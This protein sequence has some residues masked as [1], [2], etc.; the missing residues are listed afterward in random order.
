MPSETDALFKYYSNKS[1]Y[2]TIRQGETIFMT[3]AKSVHFNDYHIHWRLHFFWTLA[4][5]CF[6]F[7][8]L[9][10]LVPLPGYEVLPAFRTYPA[11]FLDTIF[12]T[13]ACALATRSIVI[14][15][16]KS[17]RDG[18]H[19]DSIVA[20]GST[21]GFAAM[22]SCI[23]HRSG[24]RYFLIAILVTACTLL[25]NALEGELQSTVRI[26]YRIGGVTSLNTAECQHVSS[27]DYMLASSAYASGLITNTISDATS[28]LNT[29]NASQPMKSFTISIIK[30]SL[31]PIQNITFLPPQSNTNILRRHY[32]RPKKTTT[33]SAVQEQQTESI[34]GLYTALIT[35]S[36]TS[37]P[38]S[39][40]PV[41]NNI[42]TNNI[43]ANTN[44][45]NMN[46]DIDAS[47][48]S[49]TTA[50]TF[51]N[52]ITA[53]TTTNPIAASTTTN[54]IAASTNAANRITATAN[55][56]NL[57][58]P[59]SATGGFNQ[60]SPLAIIRNNNNNRTAL[61]YEMGQVYGASEIPMKLNIFRYTT[62]DN[63]EAVIMYSS[64]TN[65]Y[66][67]G[68]Y[69][70]VISINHTCQSRG[71]NVIC[72]E[73]IS[74]TADKKIVADALVA[75]VRSGDGLYG[76]NSGTG[77]TMDI[78]NGINSTGKNSK[79]V[80][81]LFANPLCNNPDLIPSE[82][83]ILIPYSAARL[84]NLAIIW[85]ILFI[86]LWIIGVYLIGYTEHTWT[87]LASTGNML[88][89]IIS[90]SPNMFES[91]ELGASTIQQEM[92][93]DP[94]TGQMT[95]ERVYRHGYSITTAVVG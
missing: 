91:N 8:K 7:A 5:V 50:S 14:G 90:K 40:I 44:D 95:L 63:Q 68:V 9:W 43:E 88:P 80:D 59:S 69:V 37:S 26:Y 15:L 39:T 55:M 23:R 27:K 87:Q 51:G 47:I 19:P 57:F 21:G 71:D 79:L 84:S 42:D 6:I 74:Y 28:L 24:V 18:I 2:R 38:S 35:L 48:S 83:N 70:N 49:S 31:A 61:P 93:L 75:A 73:G 58:I 54:T 17:F 94:E 85:L 52:T 22:W 34:S 56:Q 92:F 64:Q 20:F 25:G 82:G 30:T 29:L 81:S 67:A 78:V 77:L 16:L 12:L 4:V 76:T 72:D 89:Q 65:E 10:W 62:P 41:F 66:N 45:K 33:E 32:P 13:F 46:S 86:I 36:T 1:N 3:T 53:S 60:S 11:N